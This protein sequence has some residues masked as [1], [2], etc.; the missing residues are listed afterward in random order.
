MET[1]ELTE[2]DV[3]GHIFTVQVL[4]PHGIDAL[5]PITNALIILVASAL[6]SH[7][8][9]EELCTSKGDK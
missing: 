2:D 1:K 8:T 7:K 4:V 6:F 9:N 3:A 5:L